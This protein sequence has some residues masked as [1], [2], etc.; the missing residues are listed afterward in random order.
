MCRLMRSHR[1][2]VIFRREFRR[3]FWYLILQGSHLRRNSLTLQ[4][5]SLVLA[6]IFLRLLVGA[7]TLSKRFNITHTYTVSFFKWR[8]RQL[9]E[10]HLQTQ[11]RGR[12]NLNSKTNYKSSEDFSHKSTHE[13]YYCNIYDCELPYCP[14]MLRYWIGAP[15]EDPLSTTWQTFKHLGQTLLRS[16]VVSAC[17]SVD[18]T[19]KALKLSIH[20][21]HHNPPN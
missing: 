7:S 3:A 9:S 19:V 12:N 2:E 8:I 5:L 6:A 20:W 13:L 4:F 14:L 1:V 18:D 11:R 16:S 21:N 15:F 10:L 17:A